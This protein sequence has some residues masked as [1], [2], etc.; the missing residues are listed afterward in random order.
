MGEDIEEYV[1]DQVLCQQLILSR[2]IDGFYNRIRC[3]E[4]EALCNLCEAIRKV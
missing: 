4:D 1:N 2:V 3:G